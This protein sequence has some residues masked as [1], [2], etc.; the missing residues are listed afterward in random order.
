MGVTGGDQLPQAVVW[1]L[2]KVL[3]RGYASITLAPFLRRWEA[4]TQLVWGLGNPIGFVSAAAW[5]LYQWED[6][7]G[8]EAV[9]RAIRS[10]EIAARSKGAEII[11][12]HWRARVR[13]IPRREPDRL[14]GEQPKPRKHT[15]SPACLCYYCVGIEPAD[16]VG[17]FWITD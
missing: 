13:P 16:S 3:I 8:P 17:M 10:M 9:A 5:L 2:A 12:N 14:F 6:E 15:Y 1:R 4:N 7:A 11:L